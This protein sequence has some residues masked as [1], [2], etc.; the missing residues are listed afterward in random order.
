ML[1]F[2]SVITVADRRVS[3]VLEWVYGEKDKVHM[4][5]TYRIYMQWDYVNH[6]TE[7][8]ITF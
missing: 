4:L 8:S 7:N 5:S 3:A 6:N 1:R 2:F